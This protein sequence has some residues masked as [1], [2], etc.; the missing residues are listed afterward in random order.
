M[1][2]AA[3]SRVCQGARISYGKFTGGVKQELGKNLCPRPRVQWTHGEPGYPASHTST[4]PF[5]EWVSQ[6]VE[7]V[8]PISEHQR[9]LAR[10]R[11]IA[12]GLRVHIAHSH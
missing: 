5:G 1:G 12:R 7:R 4:A 6:G 11:R 9:R 2:S 8:D 3:S 10:H